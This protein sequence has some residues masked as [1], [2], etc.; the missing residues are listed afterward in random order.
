MGTSMARISDVLF[1]LIVNASV[2]EIP[3]ASLFPIFYWRSISP[4]I[5]KDNTIAENAVFMEISFP[6]SL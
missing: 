6:S 4:S 5:G 2:S 1:A 3:I